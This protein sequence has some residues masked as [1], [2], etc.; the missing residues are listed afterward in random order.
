MLQNPFVVQLEEVQIWVVH[1]R[2]GASASSTS[3]LFNNSQSNTGTWG[4]RQS[5]WTASPSDSCPGWPSVASRRPSVAGCHPCLSLLQNNEWSH[6]RP[7]SLLFMSQSNM[8]WSHPTESTKDTMLIQV[9]S[10]SLASALQRAACP[11]ECLIAGGVLASAL[12]VEAA[13]HQHE[14]PWASEIQRKLPGPKDLKFFRNMSKP[15]RPSR[16]SMDWRISGGGIWELWNL[17]GDLCHMGKGWCTMG[18]WC[19]QSA[20]L[21]WMST[22]ADWYLSF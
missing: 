9:P 19:L 4:L 13:A 7:W 18:G 22:P 3:N 8:T 17:V 16:P 5:L 14:V 11:I 10:C 15:M 2:K 20:V 12:L 21:A 6:L 1:T